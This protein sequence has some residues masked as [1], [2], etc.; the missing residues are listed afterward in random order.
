MARVVR[1]GGSKGPPK[2]DY[3]DVS[4][5][6]DVTHADSQV[7]VRLRGGNA[8]DDASVASS[9]EARKSQHSVYP[10]YVSFDEWSETVA[11]LAE[12]IFL[13]LGVYGCTFVDQLSDS[14]MGWARRVE[15]GD[16]RCRLQVDFVTA[17]TTIWRKGFSNSSLETSR[18]RESAQR[19]E[20]TDPT[21]DWGWSLDAASLRLECKTTYQE[22]GDN[23][24][25]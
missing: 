2:K 9:S 14:V 6:L 18:K 13:R 24:N 19:E 3:T 7:R 5:V 16:E 23:S 8:A 10:K 17:R 22:G 15:G 21:M 4:T 25:N 12:E 1:R 20:M 11:A